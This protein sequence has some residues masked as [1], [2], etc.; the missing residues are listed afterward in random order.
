MQAHLPQ[1]LFSL[2][3]SRRGH[4]K[5]RRLAIKKSCFYGREGRGLRISES[6]QKTV[7][8]PPKI[9]LG[10]Q[11][12]GRKQKQ[13]FYK[14]KCGPQWPPMALRVGPPG[15]SALQ[16]DRLDA[17]VML[18]CRTPQEILRALGGQ[19]TF[20]ENP[21]FFPPCQIPCETNSEHYV[22]SLISGR[23]N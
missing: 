16:N 2:R 11:V 13:G 21:C 7:Q 3:D 1:K 14:K 4:L 23:R 8:I 15:S 22:S 6:A 9:S 10:D 18:Q 17:P 20:R 19:I 12:N 5:A